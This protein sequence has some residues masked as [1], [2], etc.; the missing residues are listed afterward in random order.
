[1]CS[2]AVWLALLLLPLFLPATQQHKENRMTEIE[3]LKETF[4]K[5]RSTFEAD[6]SQFI[7]FQTVS[8]DP[9]FLPHFT[10]C[11]KWLKAKLQAMGAEV[12]I[13]NEEGRPIIFASLPST[14]KDAP[15]LLLYNHYDVQPVDPIQEWQSDPFTLVVEG[16]ILRARGTTDDKGPCLFTLS[17]VK[18]LIKK[19]LPFNIKI[20]LEGEEEIASGS[21]IKYCEIKKEALKADYAMI[22]DLGMREKD[23]PAIPIGT[24]GV[25]T[26]SLSLQGANQDLHS[27][28]Y[29]GMAPNPLQAISEL[30]ARL[31]ND[32]GSVAVPGFYD[33]VHMP[34]EQERAALSLHM[35]E[36]EWEKEFGQP[37][38]AGEQ[39]FLPL[40]RAGLRPTLEINGIGGGYTGPGIKTVI[41][42]EVK[43]KISCRLVPGQDPQTVAEK[44]QTF[45]HA[46][47]P[48]GTSLDVEILKGRGMAFRAQTDSET[49]LAVEKAMGEVWGGKPERII[50]GGSVPIIPVLQEA[51]QSK[52]LLWGITLPSDRMHAPNENVS[53]EQLERGFLTLS[54]AIAFLANL[55]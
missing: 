8:A 7:A 40:E 12:E 20:L 38:V 30:I 44:V 24:R 42:R 47:T 3:R 45:L 50:E 25:A 43:A 22:I 48:K 51:S 26:L 37:P 11:S 13:W 29:G 10:A 27:G 16:D 55:E 33:S 36:T 34:S 9:A 17:A 52:L 4:R 15:T 32:D 46:N 6:L 5:N 54:L 28:S 41:P 2:V 23:V 1:M 31:H 19:E 18:E 21:L 14:K 35:D 53:F 39:Q 49:F